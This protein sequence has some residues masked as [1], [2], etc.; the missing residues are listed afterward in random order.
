[1]DLQTVR[2]TLLIVFCIFNLVAVPLVYTDQPFDGV[3]NV[4]RVVVGVPEADS[5]AVVTALYDLTTP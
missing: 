4:L 2:N 3:D 5:R 1:M